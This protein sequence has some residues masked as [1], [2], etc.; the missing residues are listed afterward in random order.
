MLLEALRNKHA[1]DDAPW[2]RPAAYCGHSVGEFVALYASNVVSFRD[3]AILLVE[4]RMNTLCVE[5]KSG[6]YYSGL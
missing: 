4:K 6:V 3:C 1:S 2:K 5:G